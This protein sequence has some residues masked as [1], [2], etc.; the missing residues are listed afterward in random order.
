MKNMIIKDMINFIQF[1]VLKVKW[2]VWPHTGRE[3]INRD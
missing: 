3:K 2:R 1:E